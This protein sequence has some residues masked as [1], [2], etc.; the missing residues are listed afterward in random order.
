[1]EKVKSPRYAFH[2]HVNINIALSN[3]HLP[4]YLRGESKLANFHA[5]AGL[6]KIQNR[7]SRIGNGAFFH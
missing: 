4:L 7:L 2:Y 3:I 6:W 1:M 5:L